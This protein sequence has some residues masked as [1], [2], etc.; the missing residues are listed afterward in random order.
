M[1]IKENILV[2]FFGYFSTIIMKFLLLHLL[3]WKNNNKFPLVVSQHTCTAHTQSIE[4]NVPS[5]SREFVSVV[6]IWRSFR[7]ALEPSS[8]RE[9]K[10]NPRAN[11]RGSL[12]KIYVHVAR[13]KRTFETR[14][15]TVLYQSCIIVLLLHFFAFECLNG[16][17]R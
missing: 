17:P 5:R 3:F 15:N 7:F 6:G 11:E 9:V 4:M 1:R 10:G 2:W 8:S 16:A 13:Q 14:W 12:N